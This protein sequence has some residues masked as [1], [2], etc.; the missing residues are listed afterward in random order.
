MR[1]LLE[2]GKGQAACLV[3][4]LTAGVGCYPSSQPRLHLKPTHLKTS[5]G[6]W[7]FNINNA[8]PCKP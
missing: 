2:S 8:Q 6:E 1:A 3:L 4:L 5:K 7:Y